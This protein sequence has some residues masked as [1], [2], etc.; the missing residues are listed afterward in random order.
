MLPD[1]G[2]HYFGFTLLSKRSLLDILAL[3]ST[4]TS[5]TLRPRIADPGLFV[6]GCPFSH[7]PCHCGSFSMFRVLGI[8]MTSF[9]RIMGDPPPRRAAKWSERHKRTS[10]ADQS[11]NPRSISGATISLRQFDRYRNNLTHSSAG[12]LIM[13]DE[14]RPFRFPISTSRD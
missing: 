6:L 9:Y 11:R 8:V 12:T 3:F 13:T 14:R 10:L 4:L 5:G 7:L 1:L 2:F